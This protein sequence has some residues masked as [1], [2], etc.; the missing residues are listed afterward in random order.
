MMHR[1]YRLTAKAIEKMID[2]DTA[3]AEDEIQTV[4]EFDS[5]EEAV[6]AYEDGNFDSDLYG[7]E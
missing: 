7:V 3:I 4:E 2:W 6:K 1:I 5:Y